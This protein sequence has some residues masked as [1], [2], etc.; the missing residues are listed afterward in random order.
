M[1]EVYAMI[2]VVDAENFEQNLISDELI[3]EEK[4][5]SGQAGKRGRKRKEKLENEEKS[6]L[7]ELMMDQLEIADLVLINKTD[8]VDEKQL[9]VVAGF[10]QGINPA[11]EILFSH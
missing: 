4:Q 7:A 3:E 11:S 6:S 5:E 2:T 9:K 10:V 8:L 1:A